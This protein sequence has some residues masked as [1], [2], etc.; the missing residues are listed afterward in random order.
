MRS[1]LLFLASAAL[2]VA[3]PALAQHAPPREQGPAAA[4]A[5]RRVAQL[6]EQ[7]RGGG[8][9]LVI[10]HER[11][12]V[13]SRD[14]DYTRPAHDCTAQRNLSIAGLASA[15]E[16]GVSIRALGIP[17]DAVFSSPMCRGTE[18]ARMMFGDHRVEP[19]LIHHDPSVPNGLDVATGLFREVLG[20]LRLGAGNTVLISHSGNIS[21]A[22]GLRLVEGEIGVLRIGADGQVE[23]LGQVHGSELGFPARAVLAEAEGHR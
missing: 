22:T 2:L 8:L 13:P 15:R 17:I 3:S 19:R 9:V 7:M 16:T 18:T 20:E 5:P 11:T 10:R 4:P 12:E 23:I 14:D 21:R 1:L 6:V